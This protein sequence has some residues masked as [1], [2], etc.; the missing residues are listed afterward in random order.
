MLDQTPEA[1]SPTFSFSYRKKEVPATFDDEW[2]SFVDQALSS[3]IKDQSTMPI[4]DIVGSGNSI[5]LDAFRQNLDFPL[6]NF[7]LPTDQYDDKETIKVFKKLNKDGIAYTFANKELDREINVI[8]DQDTGKL[9]KI[10]LKDS[11]YKPDLSQ[12]DVKNNAERNLTIDFNNDG[13]INQIIDER[14][15]KE[16]AG[17][18][19]NYGISYH[20]FRDGDGLQAEVAAKMDHQANWSVLKKPISIEKATSFGSQ[21]KNEFTTLKFDRSF[22]GLAVNR[23]SAAPQKT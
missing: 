17:K 8:Y 21:V 10:G 14:L 1:G 15:I 22:L 19:G 13:M 16:Y 20:Y 11:Q 2:K 23:F 12:P 18:P 7:L 4:K 9:L 6:K 3:N 5:S